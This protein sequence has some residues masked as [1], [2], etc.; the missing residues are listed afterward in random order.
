MAFSGWLRSNAEHWLLIDAQRRVAIAHGHSGPPA[1]RTAQE[2]FW[3]QVFA[4]A[5]RVI[6]WTLRHRVI[7]ALPGSHRQQWTFQT[8]RPRPAPPGPKPS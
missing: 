1:P 3:L 5:Y 7:T 8:P 4:P 2:R 6:P